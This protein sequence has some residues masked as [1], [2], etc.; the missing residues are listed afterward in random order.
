MCM[1]MMGHDHDGAHQSHATP[2]APVAARACAHCGYSLQTAFAFCPNCGMSLRTAS[3][4]SC[5]QKVDATWKA[6][7]YCGTELGARA[8]ATTGHVHH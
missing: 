4:P 7:P 6:C 8:S 3:C 2:Q 5:G 1:C